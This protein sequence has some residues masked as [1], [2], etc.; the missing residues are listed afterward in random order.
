[1]KPSKEQIKKLEQALARAHAAQDAPPFPTNWVYS[2]MR[3]IRRQSSSA[4]T[5]TEVPRL[6]WR[7]ATVVV[8]LSMVVAGSVLAWDAERVHT[9]FSGLFTEATLDPSLL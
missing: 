7:A 8:F 5:T 1:M 6:I 4:R 3:E 9:G 2:V